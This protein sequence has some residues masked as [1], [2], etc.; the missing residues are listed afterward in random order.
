MRAARTSRDK[1]NDYGGGDREPAHLQRAVCHYGPR[2]QGRRAQR[3]CSLQEVS[4]CGD[5][6]GTAVR[7][8]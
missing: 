3:H 7:K 5:S 6:T 4:I 8:T 2:S 1:K